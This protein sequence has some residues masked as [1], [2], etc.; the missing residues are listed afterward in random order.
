[1]RA[2][3]IPGALHLIPYAFGA[4]VP[5]YNVP[6]ANA[7][8]GKLVFSLDLLARIWMGDIK[9]WN[10]TDLVALNPNAVSSLCEPGVAHLS[11]PAFRSCSDCRACPSCRSRWCLSMPTPS[12]AR[13]AFLCACPRLASAHL[14]LSVPACADVRI[15]FA[16]ALLRSRVSIAE[17]GTGAVSWTPAKAIVVAGDKTVHSVVLNTPG[18]IGVVFNSPSLRC[19][20]VGGSCVLRSAFTHPRSSG[21]P[22]CLCTAR[23]WAAC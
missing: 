17:D 1:M 4:I 18:A 7:A 5:I 20:A 13:L 12:Q 8:G 10:H 14:L 3:V 9:H 23:L 19:A 2:A 15:P 11:Q 6:S 16:R 22:A 21:L